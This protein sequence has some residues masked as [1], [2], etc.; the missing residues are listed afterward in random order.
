MNVTYTLTF[1]QFE[2]LLNAAATLNGIAESDRF[3]PNMK[4]VAAE[5]AQAALEAARGVKPV[6]HI[7]HKA[8]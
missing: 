2:A 6:A 1:E 8:A 7:N 5:R 3:T 4:S